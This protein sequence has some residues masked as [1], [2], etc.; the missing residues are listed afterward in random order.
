MKKKPGHRRAAAKRGAVT[1]R[2]RVSGASK[3]PVRV[4]DWPAR[5]KA[6]RRAGGFTEQ[7]MAEARWWPTCACGKLDAD[8]PRGRDLTFGRARHAPKDAALFDLGAHF[9]AHVCNNNFDAAE[10][11]ILAITKRAAEVLADQR[12]QPS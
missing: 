12:K 10:A 3:K 6:A 9:V 7:D 2:P 8:I 1:Q 5:I 11:T 4:L